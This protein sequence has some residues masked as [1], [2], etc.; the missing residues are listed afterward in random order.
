MEN[1][2]RAYYE[3]EKE[4]DGPIG[5]HY[6]KLIQKLTPLRTACAGGQI[7]LDDDSANTGGGVHDGSDDEPKQRKKKKAQRFSDFC[8][9]SKLQAL[10]KEL[11]SVRSKDKTGESVLSS[12][13][14]W[15]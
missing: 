10:V 5:R 9:S 1:D 8:F 2:A 6:L 4:K 3:K 13:G 11:E 12:V 7:P 15:L 14:W